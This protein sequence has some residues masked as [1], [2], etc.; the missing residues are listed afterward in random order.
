MGPP[1]QQAAYQFFL[2]EL[3]RMAKEQNVNNEER[4]E[5]FELI[6]KFY[7][8][9]PRDVFPGFYQS[10]KHKPPLQL[11]RAIDKKLNLLDFWQSHI[12]KIGPS[13]KKQE[14]ERLLEFKRLVEENWLGVV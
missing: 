12:T 1:Y 14:I 4:E 11:F 2:D 8:H 9:Y 13:Y 6:E 10:L 5:A 7:F 3:G